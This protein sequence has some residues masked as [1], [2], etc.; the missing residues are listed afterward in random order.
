MPVTVGSW[1]ASGS[2]CRHHACGASARGTAVSRAPARLHPGGHAASRLAPR[3]LAEPHAPS[4]GSAPPLKNL[5]VRLASFPLSLSSLSPA[6]PTARS[7]SV[8]SCN[9]PLTPS[10]GERGLRKFVPPFLICGCVAIA[11]SCWQTQATRRGRLP[12]AGPTGPQGGPGP[13]TAGGEASRLDPRLGKG[14]EC[15][16]RTA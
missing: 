9:S 8:R 14:R 2:V 15:A 16:G 4:S 3:F 6:D 11:A 13:P 10:G 5:K 12:G 7:L 1:P